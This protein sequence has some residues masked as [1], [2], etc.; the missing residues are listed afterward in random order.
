MARIRGICY[1][2]RLAGRNGD[3]STP[4]DS[5]SKPGSCSAGSRKARIQGAGGRRVATGDDVAG[6]LAR[7]PRELSP[8]QARASGGRYQRVSTDGVLS[9]WPVQG[10]ERRAVESAALGVVGHTI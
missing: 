5:D 3:V 6:Q 9:P 10:A 1:S 7:S 4:T 2:G 8:A